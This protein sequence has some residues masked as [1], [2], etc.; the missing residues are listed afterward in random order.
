MIERT[1]KK[2]RHFA[3]G[4]IVIGGAL[5]AL[6]AWRD[7]TIALYIFGL[8]A[9]WGVLGAAVPVA[10][11]PLFIALT[12][13]GLALGWVNTRLILGLLY[14]LVFTPLGLLFR[15]I[16]KDPL[17][18]RIEKNAGTYWQDVSGRPYDTK[19]FEKQF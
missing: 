17:N 2:L 8:L 9:L 18:R 4:I 6:M 1:P 5:A 15:L 7:H 12:Y 11:S 16:G 13:I 14:F 19:H 3:I 10:I